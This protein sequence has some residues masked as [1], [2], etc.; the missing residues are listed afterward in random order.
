MKIGY[1]SKIPGNLAAAQEAKLVEEGFSNVYMDGRGA[2][3]LDEAL[4]CFR[5]KPGE[6]GVAAD[7]RVFGRTQDE[8]FKATSKITKS[9]HKLVDVRAP[10]A[11]VASLIRET[12]RQLAA[13]NRWGG[14]KQRAKRQGAIGGV[15]KAQA[16]A[17]KRQAIADDSVIR[18]IVSATELSW[19]RK[20]K[21][22]GISIS[23]LRRHYGDGA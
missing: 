5:D 3:S 13:W 8:I 15:A 16:A 7:L 21:I 17:A 11:D 20:S 14:N 22:L 6:L 18:A 23:S 1:C 2:E 9:G 12:L 4:R 19:P 10:D